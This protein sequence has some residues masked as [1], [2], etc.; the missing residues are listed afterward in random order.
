MKSLHDTAP[1][2]AAEV[3]TGMWF[4]V[5]TVMSI[6][7]LVFL[8]AFAVVFSEAWT[9]YRT[10]DK[11]HLKIEALRN[12]MLA[13]GAAGAV[14]VG[15]WGLAFAAVRTHAL[16]RQA[17]VAEADSKFSE[18]KHESEAF[19]TAIEQLGSTNFAVRLGA[20]YTLEALAKSS[21]EL[22]GPIFE[23][24]CAYIR[25]KSPIKDDQAAKDK[26]NVVVQAILTVI[27]RRDPDRDPPGYQIDLHDTNLFQANLS[28]GQFAGANLSE[29]RLDGANLIGANLEGALLV[30]ARLEGV[31]LIRANLK[32][33]YLMGARLENTSF[34]EAG[35]HGAVLTDITFST[36]TNVSDADFRGAR[37]IPA[38][39]DNDF[40]TTVRGADSALW[41][42]DDD[43]DAWDRGSKNRVRR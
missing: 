34:S 32:R 33:A 16:N 21:M 24:L 19:A 38:H 20:V 9:D 14:I 39:P 4:S 11:E 8:A 43:P 10:I 12:M 22:H 7:S 40:R 5:F 26:I 6:L 30:K 18:K 31:R 25:N 37:A 41:P 1:V 15:A 42:N 13:A 3:Q 2:P 23:T 29:T 28:E 17:N 35:F 27:G 36:N